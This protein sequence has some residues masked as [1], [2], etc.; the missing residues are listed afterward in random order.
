[1]VNFKLC[2]FNYNLKSD[3]VGEMFV[4]NEEF[5][6]LLS[7]LFSDDGTRAQKG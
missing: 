5:Y 6:S 1:M 7:L 3:G 4:F 2:I